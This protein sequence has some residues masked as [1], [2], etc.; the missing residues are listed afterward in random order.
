MCL[1][2]LTRRLHHRLHELHFGRVQRS[3]LI[4]HYEGVAATRCGAKVRYGDVVVALRGLVCFR[5]KDEPRGEGRGHKRRHNV[6]TRE[7]ARKRK[8]NMPK[9]RAAERQK[10]VTSTDPCRFR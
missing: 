9:E 6:S 5:S 10:S 8:R 7:T 2:V 4:A 3:E 1:P